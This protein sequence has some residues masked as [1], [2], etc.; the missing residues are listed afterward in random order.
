MITSVGY[1]KP[2]C[3]ANTGPFSPFSFKVLPL[4]EASSHF[5]PLPPQ[6]ELGILLS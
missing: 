1:L 4:K 2:L 3:F 5:L 6:P